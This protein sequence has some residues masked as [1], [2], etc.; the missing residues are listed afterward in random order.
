MRRGVTNGRYELIAKPTRSYEF[1]TA[2]NAAGSYSVA[3]A[4]QSNEEQVCTLERMH[5]S[6]IKK[7]A[8]QVA[9]LRSLLVQCL[10][11]GG[12]QLLNHVGDGRT[13]VFGLF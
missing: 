13:K 5:C 7:E 10:L 6:V 1:I 2:V 12:L 8:D 3:T 9:Q 11:S 4:R